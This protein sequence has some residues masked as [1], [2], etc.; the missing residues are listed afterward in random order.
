ME[1]LTLVQSFTLFRTV[2]MVILVLALAYW[3]TVLMKKQ[4]VKSSVSSNIKV[5]EQ[6]SVGQDRR[7]LLLNVGEHNYLVG[8]SQ[9]GIQLVAEVD[10]DY[11]AAQPP[12]PEA[13]AQPA[14]GAILEKYLSLH[15][16]K[17]G[18]DL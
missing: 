16:K 8:V 18:G 11:Q 3:C 13:T 5:L 15:Q 10:G 2:I 14:F 9:A 7:I 1:D 17:K 12:Q 6:I 4:W